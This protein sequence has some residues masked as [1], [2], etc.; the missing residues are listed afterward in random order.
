[1][2]VQLR[3]WPFRKVPL[4]GLPGPGSVVPAHACLNSVCA[5]ADFPNRTALLLPTM[6]GLSGHFTDPFINDGYNI[7]YNNISHFSQ[8]DHTISNHAHN[9]T[10]TATFSAIASASHDVLFWS[11]NAAYAS[12][13]AL[14]LQAKYELQAQRYD[15]ATCSTY[16]CIPHRFALEISSHSFRT[17]LTSSLLNV[18]TFYRC[19]I[20]LPT[21][22][23][24]RASLFPI[25][26]DHW[27][28][29]I[30]QMFSFGTRSPGSS[31]LK[32]KESV[33]KTLQDLDS[34]LMMMAI[35]SQSHASKYSCRLQN[36][37]GMNSI[38]SVLTPVHGQ[39][40]PQKLLPIS[41]TF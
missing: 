1:M 16:M 19:L 2:F 32:N 3:K 9:S 25:N 30:T 14:H 26:H 18:P 36:R 39:R 29:K 15:I 24:L 20:P 31:I 27:M 7:P 34:S 33:G 5:P 10:S 4:F 22:K 8:P 21:K 28:K 40:R 11:G 35:R 12:L 13:N 37:H 41:C 17:W 23:K 6:S 38:A